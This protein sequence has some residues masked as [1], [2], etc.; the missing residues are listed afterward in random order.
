MTAPKKSLSTR[1]AEEAINETMMAGIAFLLVVMG[2]N[3]FNMKWAWLKIIGQATSSVSSAAASAEVSRMLA[4][5]TNTFPFKFLFGQYDFWTTLIIASCLTLFG[6]GLKTLIVKTKGKF[7]IDIG[8]NIETPA[9][10]GF[11]IIIA[12]QI[13]TAVNVNKYLET[14][15][16]MTPSLESGY[17]VW[18]TYG[19]LFLIGAT[20]LVIGAII[21]LVGEKNKARK[22]LL[23]GNAIF[24]SSFILIIYYI[25]IRILTIDIILNSSIGKGL[26][27]F[28]ISNQYSN[29]SI[30][31]C[32]FLF[33]FGKELRRFG[34][35][36]LKIEKR[37]HHV[38]Q[39]KKDYNI[40]GDSITA[41]LIPKHKLKVKHHHIRKE[42]RTHPAF[43]DPNHPVHRYVKP[44]GNYKKNL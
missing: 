11:I 16:F 33:T 8:K 38:E 25:I 3:Y 40:V 14:R 6:I 13:W 34:R 7:I 10:I 43:H 32:V 27:I 28:I 42:D 1:I 23:I 21:K 20:F 17:F 31:V 39:M 37:L 12:L 5:L 24:T 36:T 30:I 44:E 9:I 41:K 18:N 22:T 4:T 15:I 29:F 19:Q 26:S 35:V 2:I